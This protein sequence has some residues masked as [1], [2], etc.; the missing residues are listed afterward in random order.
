MKNN[1]GQSNDQLGLIYSVAVVL[2]ALILAF[3]AAILR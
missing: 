3:M 1:I 2:S